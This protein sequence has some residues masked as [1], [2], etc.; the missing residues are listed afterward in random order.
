MREDPRS[1]G[2]G[3]QRSSRFSRQLAIALVAGVILL[4]GALGATWWMARQQDEMVRVASRRMVTGGVESLVERAQASL[5][6][7]ALWD[8]CYERILANDITW[9]QRNIAA[10]IDVGTYNLALVMRPHAAPLAFEVGGRDITVAEV[11]DPNVLATINGLLADEPIDSNR[12]RT[13]FARSKGEVWLFAVARVVPQTGRPPA[14]ATDAD[15][16]RLIFGH[17]LTTQMVSELG[18]RFAIDSL[19]V[20]DSP[21]P[22]G[23]ALPL[24]GPD[25]PSA[26]L[27]WNPPTPGRSVLEASLGPLA[28]VLGAFGIVAVLVSRELVRSARSLEVALA[29][30]QAADSLKSEFLSNVSHEL[31]TPLS[32]IIGLVQLL[33]M[34]EQDAESREMLDLLLASANAQ[35]HLVDGLL[36]ISRI[37][38][39][40]VA[41]DRTPFDPAAVVEATV[42]LAATDIIAKTLAFQVDIAPEA[43]QPVLGDP[44]AFRQIVT[45]LVG[46]ALKFTPSGKIAVTLE[47]TSL[48]TGSRGLRLVVADTGVGIDPANHRRIFERFV[49]VDGSSTRAVGGA[50]LGLA[51]TAALVEL[52]GGRIEV[53]SA[54]GAGAR[55]T[56]TLPLPAAGAT[57]AQRDAA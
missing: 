9:M 10:S 26:W 56:V 2:A 1:R 20:A 37:E 31:R 52:M 29:G 35:L 46:N 53:E 49:Q 21:V 22:G 48:A 47:A 6:D 39:G 11:I 17:R 43:R 15:L 34:R 45:N 19:A 32:G 8:D 5:L 57:G 33:Q 42:Q 12:A 18:Q 14:G 50:G 7:Y 16:P 23:D 3:Y 38:S 24:D 30:A 51:I 27:V 54:L 36:D 41:L 55:F 40:S 4:C 28:A 44:H 25:G 13:M